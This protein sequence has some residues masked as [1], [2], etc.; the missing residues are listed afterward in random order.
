[1]ST[2]NA[3]G[4]Q[5][6]IFYAKADTQL[7]DLTFTIKNDTVAPVDG[8]AMNYNTATDA[9]DAG[10]DAYKLTAKYDLTQGIYYVALTNV[11]ETQGWQ[12]DAKTILPTL[13]SQTPTHIYPVVYSDA[14]DPDAYAKAQAMAAAIRA[15]ANAVLDPNAAAARD[16]MTAARDNLKDASVAYTVLGADGITPATKSV[17]DVIA[18]IT[19][20]TGDL[21]DRL[22]WAARVTEA[23]RN[24]GVAVT[25]ADETEALAALNTLKS[26][27]ENSQKAATTALNQA[28]ALGLMTAG[29]IST[30][31]LADT[32][33]ALN[34]GVSRVDTMENDYANVMA[35][36]KAELDAALATLDALGDTTAV[37]AAYFAI[38]AWMLTQEPAI[39]AL[40][41]AEV[42]TALQNQAARAVDA[43][44]GRPVGTTSFANLKDALDAVS[45]VSDIGDPAEADALA[46]IAKAAGQAKLV[47]A[48]NDLT[49]ATLAADGLASTDKTAQRRQLLADALTAGSMAADAAYH[50]VRGYDSELHFDGEHDDHV[51]PLIDAD[52]S[53][54]TNFYIVIAP[55]DVNYPSVVVTLR[56]MKLEPKI[57]AADAYNGPV[58]RPFQVA[59]GETDEFGEPI[60]DL[61]NF[62]EYADDSTFY[63]DY[64]YDYK[65]NP[66]YAKYPADYADATLAGQ[67][68]YPDVMTLTQDASGTVQTDMP[69]FVV[70]VRYPDNV[71]AGQGT[72][73]TLKLT[74]ENPMTL[75]SKYTKN[76]DGTVS[77]S[78]AQKADDKDL[79]VTF[80]VDL[81]PEADKYTA[82]RFKA[83]LSVD[84]SGNVEREY[85]VIV[86]Y[87][88]R[89][90]E[91]VRL[92][93]FGSEN[94]SGDKYGT[95]PG[96]KL[97]DNL[98]RYTIHK[99]ETE[100]DSYEVQVPR[101]FAGPLF[102]E[103]AAG[104][105]NSLGEEVY[106]LGSK[107]TVMV[108]DATG[109]RTYPFREN[110]S[111]P[112]IYL[113]RRQVQLYPDLIEQ[114]GG[115]VVEI[116]VTDDAG[117]EAKTYY[118]HITYQSAETTIAVRTKNVGDN[119]STLPAQTFID[120]AGKDQEFYNTLIDRDATIMPFRIT[121]DRTYASVWM[122]MVE[123]T[124]DGETVK[125]PYYFLADTTD[126]NTAM[127]D[128]KPTTKDWEDNKLPS[129]N[130]INDLLDKLDLTDEQLAKDLQTGIYVPFYVMAEDGTTV[131]LRLLKFR[132]NFADL[133]A[134][135]LV[136][137]Y[138][139]NYV[140]A[141]GKSG[142]DEFRNV[143]A[144]R[145][146]KETDKD[147]VF[148][149]TIPSDLKTL[150]LTL[151]PE[152]PVAQYIFFD[153]AQ[154]LVDRPT[155]MDYG[156]RN[157]YPLDLDVTLADGVTPNPNYNTRHK[158]L[159]IDLQDAT[160][161]DKDELLIYMYVPSGTYDEFGK[162]TLLQI[163]VTLKLERVSTDRT[164]K[165]LVTNKDKSYV[166]EAVA[167]QPADGQYLTYIPL[168]TEYD[169]T[170]FTATMNDEKAQIKVLENDG[171]DADRSYISGVKG[172]YDFGRGF[173]TSTEDYVVVDTE[174]GTKGFKM[175]L[176]VLSAY[177]QL[178]IGQMIAD[179]NAKKPA[180]RPDDATWA[181]E[182]AKEYNKHTL[183]HQVFIIP[184]NMNLDVDVTYK[185]LGENVALNLDRD[186]EGAY[187]VYDYKSNANADRFTVMSINNQDVQLQLLDSLGNVVYDSTDPAHSAVGADQILMQTGA[188]VLQ[189]GFTSATPDSAETKYT[190][191]ISSTQDGIKTA[192]G[193][194]AYLN[195]KFPLTIRP[196]SEDTSV[197][198]W[199]TYEVDGTTYRNEA[200]WNDQ[201]EAYEAAIGLNTVNMKIEI[202]ATNPAAKPGLDLLGNHDGG[203]GA[204]ASAAEPYNTIF[205]KS[206]MLIETAAGGFNYPTLNGITVEPNPVVVDSEWDR[207]WKMVDAN[208]ITS[209][210][211]FSAD[212][213]QVTEN[214]G[215]AAQSVTM[216]VQVKA[217]DERVLA[218]EGTGANT[219]YGH[220]LVLTR[221]SNL[222][223]LDVFNEYKR[224]PSPVSGDRNYI[225]DAEYY[226]AKDESTETENILVLYLDPYTPASGSTPASGNANA[227]GRFVV[228][229]GASLKITTADGR[230]V[231]GFPDA[232][233]GFTPGT[234]FPVSNLN[235]GVYTVTVEAQDQNP[236]NTRVY[237]L[238]VKDKSTET[239]TGFV[240]A[241]GE[242]GEYWIFHDHAPANMTHPGTGTQDDPYKGFI[243]LHAST[244]KVDPMDRNAV[245]TRIERFADAGFTASL[246]VV[247][248]NADHT[249]SNGLLYDVYKAMSGAYKYGAAVINTPAATGADPKADTLY[250]AVTLVSQ[251]TG[252]DGKPLKT[253]TV[254]VAL[255]REDVVVDT[256][257]VNANGDIGSIRE[258]DADQIHGIDQFNLNVAD[259]EMILNVTTKGVATT[260][261]ADPS[262]RV[263]GFGATVET[264]DSNVPPSAIDPTHPERFAT[265]YTNKAADG[266]SASVYF[267][268]TD[269]DFYTADASGRVITPNAR[270]MFKIEIFRSNHDTTLGV[271]GQVFIVDPTAGVWDRRIEAVARPN[272]PTF[273]EVSA[274][275]AKG[276]DAVVQKVGSDYKFKFEVDTPG[277]KYLTMLEVFTTGTGA[278][279]SHT[280]ASYVEYYNKSETGKGQLRSLES[281]L[282]NVNGAYTDVAFYVVSSS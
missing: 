39:P 166:H 267:Q 240:A 172:V 170:W 220:K 168:S 55:N 122:P 167:D 247:S 195:R 85:L 121:A 237:T 30:A 193:T 82:F 107:V 241:E 26:Q 111:D 81:R 182:L 210:N 51:L 259:M 171:Q 117:S 229:E 84:G 54:N 178:R 130:P 276:N 181:A 103:A 180:D 2:V 87:A 218:K 70:K 12:L 6:R 217:Q 79:S 258:Y 265:S 269:T 183:T 78:T 52:T 142:T 204:G 98:T 21:A 186:A 1:S 235:R 83:S 227:L 15:N 254:Y 279:K 148:S 150:T 136:A 60:Y 61:Y 134:E 64:P 118:L 59:S 133:L 268:V 23:F 36:I 138:D 65:T 152:M 146:T 56:V 214:V 162:E 63:P 143:Y 131:T 91:L 273:Y 80:N 19:A 27:A 272:N 270:R 120:A 62:L 123:K 10:N 205:V 129:G 160:G 32:A 153:E 224:D 50:N 46:A 188:S 149:L 77:Y 9:D 22:A 48:G 157:D 174:T 256:D 71:P 253:S 106:F 165:S 257:S 42:D 44:Y 255:S 89:G 37:D 223:E 74:T 155:T 159:D 144:T 90:S 88:E 11:D 236:A 246:G 124:V 49:A 206:G 213:Y 274:D 75:V 115:Q 116:I 92:L 161:A 194:T 13:S 242:Q 101:S 202:E 128:H 5:V 38:Q 20:A 57:V 97:G 263:T 96:G 45:A 137:D 100:A 196:M 102:L 126:I 266:T 76:A 176:S 261:G 232:N 198:I 35:G 179:Y 277:N 251:A 108:P 156:T 248:T 260:G 222:A 219:I 249:T 197:K 3:K 233:R 173:S 47:F 145:L 199:V 24:D 282:Y 184:T 132:W 140:G 203:T 228:S 31:T 200:K 201:T 187:S 119:A 16:A 58:L 163:P 250:Y 7:E 281:N 8:M 221:K 40:T 94:Y 271:G 185:R 125:V 86:Q 169:K 216:R 230:Q 238:I 104:Y 215:N 18:D 190:I 243:P 231:A 34:T 154:S 114:D 175:D 29:E 164:L 113:A 135:A 41:G 158:R 72:R 245:I 93:D 66:Y 264:A 252:V 280:D 278:T 192:D 33:A 234:N 69:I 191:V 212:L 141:D 95:E 239:R 105:Y 207:M 147:Q 25:Y 112:R 151:L 68:I 73:A 275:I 209:G 225:P 110:A 109:K 43:Y 28:V 262:V 244:L 4:Q 226:Q 99:S 17:L 139:W 177:G 14:T 53:T 208:F 189:T 127:N 67:Y 211:V